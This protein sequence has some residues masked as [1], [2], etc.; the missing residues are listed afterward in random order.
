MKVCASI[1]LFITLLL[2]LG[3]MTTSFMVTTIQNNVQQTTMALHATPEVVEVCG[4]K[5]CRRAGGGARL[6][7][8]VNTVLEENGLVDAVKVEKCDCQVRNEF[9][10]GVIFLLFLLLFLLLLLV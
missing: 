1:Q 6:E 2:S 8:L 3:V 5:D 4:F 9:Q 7:N 10:C